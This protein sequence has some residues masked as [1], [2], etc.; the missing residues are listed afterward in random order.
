MMTKEDGTPIMGR[1]EDFIACIALQD[2]P[3]IEGTWEENFIYSLNLDIITPRQ[4]WFLYNACIKFRRYI[5]KVEFLDF[6]WNFLKENPSPPAK[7]SDVTELLKS[8][9][10]KKKKKA[11]SCA[12]PAKPSHTKSKSDGFM[13]LNKFQTVHCMWADTFKE[14]LIE[15]NVPTSPDGRYSIEGMKAVEDLFVKGDLRYYQKKRPA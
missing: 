7:R 5:K 8:I 1:E 6:C 13:D 4:R 10:P 9:K 11:K 2:V 12:P 3:I 14:T 15:Y